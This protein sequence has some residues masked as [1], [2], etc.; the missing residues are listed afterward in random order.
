LYEMTTSVPLFA[1]SYDR[2]T[3][4]ARSEITGWKGLSAAMIDQMEELHGKFEATALADLLTWCLDADPSHRPGSIDEVL[5]HA[6]F[7]REKGSLRVDFAVQRL[8]ELVQDRKYERKGCKVMIS[9]AWHD[10][11]FVLGKLAPELAAYCSSLWLDRLGG[12]QGMGEWVRDSM[13]RGVQSADVVLAVVSPAYIQSNHCGLEMHFVASTGTKVVPIMY[14]VPYAEWPP[15]QIGQTPMQEQF[16]TANGDIKMYIDMSDPAQFHTKLHR[17]LLP[18]LDKAGTALV[19]SDD[20]LVA[21]N[22]T[23]AMGDV[24]ATPAP[25]KPTRPSKIRVEPAAVQE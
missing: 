6:F 5:D 12:E 14:G 7:N 4:T 17:E 21:T 8:R 22:A 10:T 19:A 3:A 2:A 25:G 20:L 23:K 11:Q 15:K 9:Y 13:E 1:H 24:G 16:A 18:R